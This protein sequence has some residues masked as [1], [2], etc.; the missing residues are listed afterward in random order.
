MTNVKRQQS[1][2]PA[3]AVRQVLACRCLPTSARL[4][5]PQNIN[6]LLGWREWA[7]AFT[8]ATALLKG[9]RAEDFW[10]AVSR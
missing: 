5:T 9:S 10:W 7:E 2:D 3:L 8:Y 1:W 4:C 6:K